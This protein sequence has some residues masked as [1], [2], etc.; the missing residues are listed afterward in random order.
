[1]RYGLVRRR[2]ALLSL[3][4]T[5]MA[6]R[7]VSAARPKLTLAT[8]TREPLVSSPGR[9]GFAEEVARD[10]FERVGH[11]LEVVTLP[12]ERALVN[13][14]AGIE[15]GDLYRAAGFEKD[16]PNLVQVPHP[17]IEQEFVAFALRSDIAVRGWSD[18]APYNV[19]Y[20]TGQKIIER[21]LQGSGKALSVRD[22]EQLFALLA[23]GRI[24]LAINNRWVG[25]AVAQRAGIPVRVLEPPLLRVPM[26]MYLHRKHEALVQPLAA[27]LAAARRDGTWQGLHDRI[28]KPLEAAR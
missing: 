23:S 10:A 6:P 28:L 15:D 19:A 4:T 21:H 24:D 1:M 3:G 8:G 7:L 18:L 25:L 2:L 26:F 14:N 9:P 22:S 5:L 16:Y 27:A 11:A 12:I 17:L 13:A 20:I